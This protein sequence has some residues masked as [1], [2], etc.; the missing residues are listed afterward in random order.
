MPSAAVPA[1]TRVIL[2]AASISASASSLLAASPINLVLDTGNNTPLPT[3]IPN[4]GSPVVRVG[5]GNPTATING[6]TIRYIGTES[7]APVV[8]D[9]F[10]SGQTP[11]GTLGRFVVLGD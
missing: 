8:S 11:T 2:A 1:R 4:D 3:R 5:P 9:P 7:V 6:V 10:S